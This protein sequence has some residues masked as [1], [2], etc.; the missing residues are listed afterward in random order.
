MN[1]RPLSDRII[2]ALLWTA[3][4]C[5]A[6]GVFFSLT[7]F[8][9][10]LPPTKPVAVG[11]VTVLRYSKLRDYLGIA[12]FFLT[13]PPLTILFHR[14][15]ERLRP[16]RTL[17]AILFLAPYLLA[18]FFYL[19]TGKAGWILA[20]P[21]VLSILAPRMLDIPRSLFREELRP[22]HALLFCEAVSWILFRYL[23]TGRR[24]A[25]I[26]TLFLEVVFVAALLALFWAVAL[27]IAHIA[28][29]P[30]ERVVT[31]GLPL[32]VL[33]FL[34]LFWIP[35]T[36][37]RL[38]ILIAL[39][40]GVLIRKP[41]PPRA[42]WRLCAFVILPALIYL[43][44]Y[45]STA[46][47][48]QWIDLFHRGESI[49]PASDYLRGKV[50][51]RDTFPLHGMLED[52]VLDSW[53]MQL[54]GRSLEVSVVSGVIVGGF[55]AVSIWF[56][57]LAVFESIPL[58]M[59]CVAMGAWTTAENN[60]TFFQ[61]AAVALFWYA[62]KRNSRW[63]AIFSGVFAG[64]ALFF[65]YEIGLYTIAAAI[66]VL[67]IMRR[68]MWAF[69]AGV[70]LGA[71]PFVIYLI[72]RGA[73]GDF[74]LTSF[75]VIPRIIDAV[76]SLPFPD[77]VSTFRQNLNLHTLSDFVLFEKFHLILSPLVIAIAA[78][79]LIQRWLRKRFDTFD[80]ALLVLTVFA[81][82]TQRTAFGRAEF[83]H[84]YFAAFLV[85]P[86]LVMLAILFTRKLRETARDGGTAFVAAIVAVLVPV[87][88][89]LLWIPD[90][91]NVRIDDLLNYQRRVLH[92]IRDGHAE[93]VK[94]RIDA[95]REEIRKL[96]KR[97]EPIF[98]FS[99]Q[100]AFYFFADRPNPTRFYQVPILSPKD[101][102]AETI[103]ALEKS[104]PKVIIRT[105]PEQLDRFDG[106]PND[107]RAQAVSAYIDDCYRFYKSV[108]GVELW[109]RLDAPRPLTVAQ[110]LKRIRLPKPRELVE[111]SR[112]RAVFPL[113][114]NHEGIAGA[115]WVSDLTLH[116][117]FREPISMSLRYVAG[118]VR[119]DRRVTLAP[120]KTMLWPD[121]AGTLF[122][123]NDAIG[124]LWIE[125]RVNRAPVASVKTY[126]AA[127]DSHASIEPALTARDSATAG[128]DAAELTIIGIPEPR[129]PRRVNV[130]IVNTGTIPATFRIV[131]G[132]KSI[133]QGVAEDEVWIV[134]DIEHELGVTI[135]ESMNIR[136]TPIAG[137]GVAFASIVSTSG[138]NQF[139]AAVP[140][141]QQ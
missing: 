58:A 18:P 128:G 94:F 95:V 74:A 103:A 131:V 133:E 129:T 4:F 89:V 56:L 138:D 25:H 38:A 82:V 69:F 37:P 141:Q 81:A 130:G 87:V 76:W 40:I 57:G 85:G 46:Q 8:F 34:P 122:G 116:N 119:I 108:R 100:P 126:D 113:V 60:R 104:K 107:L 110:Y 97:N 78:V 23:A 6:T 5:F 114:G 71:A 66:L 123:T 59:L 137:T 111:S 26:P 101:F 52:G 132:G 64:L 70:A 84:Q 88:G 91:I 20:L 75:I 115:R 43:V 124:T 51:Y 90:L 48:S 96:T 62:L 24:F 139:I 79:Y 28:Q 121:V 117:P 33:P 67:L 10:S 73:F 53:L 45:A 9:P 61:V 3:A 120:R 86:M 127:H 41:L 118:G 29:V 49:G 27:F 135:D 98:D 140:A 17:P 32:V 42:T 102:Q 22:Y 112:D 19:T 11:L 7:L 80:S 105:S 12:L 68:R 35:T 136:I 36:Q 125:H 31:A 21:I 54:F 30:F 63:G 2:A 13:V 47:G 99:N 83:R 55:L 1:A 72:A 77:V 65:S 134:P 14:Y 39:L 16:K 15:G 106:V 44:S 92:V 93:E 50:P 109:T